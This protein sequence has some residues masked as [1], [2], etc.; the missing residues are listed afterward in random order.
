MSPMWAKGKPMRIKQKYRKKA[1]LYKHFA[2]QWEAVLDFSE[3]ALVECFEWESHGKKLTSKNNGYA[4][5][6]GWLDVNI[7]MW[8]EDIKAGLLHP[9]E[10]EDWAYLVR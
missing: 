6:K 7:T 10:L 3:D 1:E 5:G 8:K 9:D 4:C 2:R